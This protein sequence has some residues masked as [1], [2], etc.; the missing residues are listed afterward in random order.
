MHRGHPHSGLAY[1]D[2]VARDSCPS[3]YPKGIWGLFTFSYCRILL[4]SHVQQKTSLQLVVWMRIVIFPK[5]LCNFLSLNW[6]VEM[7]QGR[8]E[9]TVRKKT[10]LFVVISTSDKLR[11]LGK[12]LNHSL[13]PEF[14][15]LYNGDNNS[16]HVTGFVV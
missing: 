4:I 10:L 2:R 1:H 7:T 9:L 13:K 16:T 11:D 15:H 5:Q 3:G 6:E 8:E 14:L 12:G